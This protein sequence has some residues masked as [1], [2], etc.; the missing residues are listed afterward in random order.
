MSLWD[1]KAAVNEATEVVKKSAKREAL[2]WFLCI[3]I[4]IALALIIRQ[5][6]FNVVK[7]DGSSMLP[8]L[9]NND[10]LI[11][12]KLGYTPDNG[13]IIVLQKDGLDPY[14]KR[15][16]ATEGQTVDIDFNAHKVFVDGVELDEPYINEPTAVRGD[17]QFPV[18]VNEDCVFVL[19]DNRNH[20]SDSRF[21]TVGL[22]HKS[23]IL[24]K[25]VLRFWPFSS[26]R[27][28]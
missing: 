4:A 26:I 8:T 22:V 28:F 6:V 19:G 12:W 25:A 10:R 27:T 9:E 15:I 23:D 7:V 20:S 1:K 3:V 13:D 24:G 11:V 5:Y 21:S 17:V 18:T 2:E 16:I 14:I